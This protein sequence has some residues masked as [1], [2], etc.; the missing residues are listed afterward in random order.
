M[1]FPSNDV[2]ERTLS[3]FFQF[4][5]DN[6]LGSKVNRFAIDLYMADGDGDCGTYYTSICDKE[7]IGCKDSRELPKLL[8]RKFKSC[9]S[10]C[11]KSNPARVCKK[12]SCL[13]W[14]PTHSPHELPKLV[15][16]D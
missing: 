15:A 3:A 4:D 8:S 16:Q 14:T 13:A 5:Y 12:G 2:S 6:G 1:T 11:A 10:V 7:S 9:A